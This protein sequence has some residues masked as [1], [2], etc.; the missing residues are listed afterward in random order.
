MVRPGDPRDEDVLTR[1]RAALWPDEEPDDED[2]P[3]YGADLAAVHH[4][5][6]GNVARAAASELLTRLS[7]AGFDRGLVVDLAA[8]SGILCRHLVDAG[9]QA[10]GV[11]LSA[12][13][14]R[15]ARAVVP[16]ATLVQGSLW[17]TPLPGKIVAVSAVGEA[18]SYAADT[19]AGLS[20]LRERLAAVYRALAPGGLFLFDVAGPGRSGPTGQRER[21]FSW[22]GGLLHLVERE[23]RANRRLTRDITVFQRL[24]RLYRRSDETHRLVLYEPERLEALLDGTGFS[25]ERLAAYRDTGFLPGWHG[26]VAWKRFGPASA[27]PPD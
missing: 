3:H 23:D 12:P 18:L 20:G 22:D 1:L 16:E 7:A 4:A 8:G 13:M 19:A 6:F 9:F 15:I 27:V 21:T 10:F 14:L 2:A 25:W 26:F 11:E 17:S 5:H 24:G